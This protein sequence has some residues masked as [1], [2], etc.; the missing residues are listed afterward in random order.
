MSL[1][2]Y[3]GRNKTKRRRYR[4]KKLYLEN[5]MQFLLFPKISQY[6]DEHSEEIVKNFIS[7][8]A[9]MDDVDKL[10]IKEE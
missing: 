7:D 4:K 2:P 3:H 10:I 1:Y 8:F 5:Q 9:N 6:I